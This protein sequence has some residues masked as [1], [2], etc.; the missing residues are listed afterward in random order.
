MQLS[1]LDPAAR[2]TDPSTSH[3]AAR[4]HP[5]VRITDRDRALAALRAAGPNGLTD[6]ELGEQIGRIQTSAGKRRKELQDVGL[7]ENSGMR[8]LS[9]SGSPAIVWRARSCHLIAN[10]G[11][12][13]SLCGI[14]DA[15]PYGLAR[16]KRAHDEGHARSGAQAPH[17]CAECVAVAEHRGLL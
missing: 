8:R 10:T 4:A 15:Q 9:P 16:W 3:E 11:D 5:E 6:H 13:T 14:K 17:W 1:L 2:T 12:R 7:V